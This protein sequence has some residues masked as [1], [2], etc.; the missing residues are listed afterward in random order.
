MTRYVTTDFA[1]EHGQDLV[2]RTLTELDE[3]QGTRGNRVYYLAVPPAAMPTLV[4]ELGE[5]RT[6]TGWVRLI[7]EKPFGRDLASARELNEPLPATS[8]DE[9]FRIDHYL[10]KETVQNLLALRFANGI[11]EPIWNRQF[12]DH[13]QIT[14]AESI[15]IEGRATYYDQA[16]AIRD[17]VQNHLLQLVALTAMEP[18]IDF[19]AES[20]RNEKVKV[21]RALRTPNPR[22]V[23]RGQY[24]RGFIE[25]SM[26]R[27]TERSRASRRTRTRRR[28]SPPACSWTTGAGPT[29]RSSSARASGS[30]GARRRSRFSSSARRTLRS[31]TCTPCARTSFVHVQPNDGVLAIGG[32]PGEGMRVRTVHMDFLYGGTFRTGLPEAYERLILD[33]MLGDP[34]LFTRADEIE[35][36]WALVDV[37]AATWT[38]ERPNFPNYAAGT[39]GAGRGSGARGM[40]SVAIEAWADDCATIEEIED[41]LADLRLRVGHRGVPDLRTSVLTHLARVPQEGKPPRPRRSRAWASSTRRA[42]CCS[43]LS[44]AKGTGWRPG[45]FSNAIRSRATGGSSATRSWSCASADRARGSGQ[46]R[47]AAAA[48]DLPVFTRWRGRPRSEPSS[49]GR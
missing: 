21:L 8:E 5:R 20:V 17:I 42:R 25:E 46:R 27:A 41:A 34:T 6:T 10:G 38:R 45:F 31:R 36:Q 3:Q 28:S 40:A 39:W 19:D 43:S 9:V 23:I 37:I 2:A 44:P 12:I 18:P 24:G 48:P 7:L 22:A 26:C 13:V 49:S 11:F 4:Q 16:G 32:V 14:V 47:D 15:G 1:D 33:T 29:R 35:E 30:R